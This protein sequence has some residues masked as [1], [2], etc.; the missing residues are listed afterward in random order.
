MREILKNIVSEKTKFCNTKKKLLPLRNSVII[1]ITMLCN[2]LAKLQI[3][4]FRKTDSVYLIWIS[5]QK[6][7]MNGWISPFNNFINTVLCTLFLIFLLIFFNDF[8]SA[9]VSG[10]RV[11]TGYP[12][13]NNVLFSSSVNTSVPVDPFCNTKNKTI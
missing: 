8:S 1:S 10:K 12:S 13:A 11:G 2:L 9:L 3:H 4:V 5:I 7:E 6:D